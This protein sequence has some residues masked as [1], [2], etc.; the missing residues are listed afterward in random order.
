MLGTS[1]D[2]WGGIASVIDVYRQH[3]LFERRNIKCLATHCSGAAREKI[4]LF[5]C[6]WLTYVGMLILGR[7][8][9]THVH[10]AIETSF[11]RKAIFLIPTFLFRVPTILHLHSGAF[12]H[13]YENQCNGLMKWI[14]RFVGERVT[15]IIVVSEALRTW[16]SSTF[17]NQ[18]VVTVYNPMRLPD[19]YDFDRRIGSH[20]LFLGKL[21]S[22]KG[23]YDLLYAVRMIVDR[24]P[25]IRLI[26]GGDGEIERTREEI[27]RLCLAKNVELVGWVSGAAKLALLQQSGI[28]VLPSYSEGLPMSVLEAMATG[29]VVV[30]TRV[31]GIPEAVTDGREGILIQAGDVQS[32]AEALEGLLNHEEMRQ[33]MGIAG[34]KK[35]ESVFSSDLLI[36]V[37]EDIYDRLQINFHSSSKSGPERKKARGCDKFTH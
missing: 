8:A 14:A 26:L 4:W 7:V 36:P 27:N 29:L 35:I 17:D 28:Y 33:R 31:G 22:G 20:V 13:F 25:A 10:S 1:A 21:G 9:L 5:I 2:A 24:H 37:I 18:H 32:L 23:T 12:P 6:A 16:V 19:L 11:W 15:C 30:S 3:G 34:R